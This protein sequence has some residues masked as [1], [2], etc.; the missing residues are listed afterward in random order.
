MG[1]EHGEK[2]METWKDISGY[3]G[4]YQVSS[5]GR[6]RSL[7]YG[8]QKILKEWN[9]NGYRYVGLCKD[10]QNKQK[11]HR[12]VAKAFLGLKDELVDHKNRVTTDNRVVNLRLCTMSQNLGNTKIRRDKKASK[13]KGVTKE[14]GVKKWRVQITFNKVRRHIGVFDTELEAARA[15]ENAARSTFGEFARCN[16]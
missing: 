8:K 13:F 15:Y 4:I 9:S 10:G 3:E 11:V 7:R 1:V 2:S 5:D 6:V 12:L 14:S 16:E